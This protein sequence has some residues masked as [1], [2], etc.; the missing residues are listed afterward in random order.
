M[1]EGVRPG[2]A[3]IVVLAIMGFAA[4]LATSVAVPLA[5]RSA[6]LQLGD[7]DVNLLAP[8]VTLASALLAFAG[9]GV[10]GLI[11]LHVLR[12]DRAETQH[13]S[14]RAVAAALS[15][16]CKDIAGLFKIRIAT[17]KA[18]LERSQDDSVTLN[19]NQ[20]FP[21]PTMIYEAVAPNIGLL[22]VEL[23][24][25][26][27]LTYGRALVWKS[28]GSQTMTKGEWWEA[29]RIQELRMRNFEQHSDRLAA[30]AGLSHDKA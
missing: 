29:I 19:L 13:A 15:G 27:V 7:A 8:I 24:N 25:A 26:T 30:F 3:G 14:A 9:V 22:G 12:R 2:W 4:A 10:S 18:R 6:L 23:A 1:A 28:Y 20:S 17:A 5:L 11:G 21:L 16:E